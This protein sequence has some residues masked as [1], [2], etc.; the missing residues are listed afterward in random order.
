M[1]PGKW[2]PKIVMVAFFICALLYFTSYAI[3]TLR[4][5]ITTTV[6]HAATVEDSVEGSGLAIR[7]EKPVEGSGD[8]MEV[9]PAE[10][11]TVGKGNP[12]ALI[13]KDKDALKQHQA[14][15]K[16][17][18]E[19]D[20]L[21][22]VISRRSE[23][24]D[25]VQLGKDIITS[26]VSVRSTIAQE[27]LSKLGGEVQSLENMIYQQ[28]YTYQGNESVTKELNQLNEQAKKLQKSDA[29]AVSQVKARWAGTFSTMVDGYENVLTPKVLSGLTPSKLEALKKGRQE[30]KQGTYLGKVV[31]GKIWY[32]AITLDEKDI[33]RMYKGLAVTVR[34]DDAAGD[35]PMTVFNIGQAENGKVVVVFASGNH[36]D[37]TSLLRTQSVS[38]IYNSYNGFRIPKKALRTEGGKY[39]VYRV[40][41]AQLE[42][43]Q[44]K[45]LTETDDYFVVWQGEAKT[46]NGAQTAQSEL[47]KAKQIRDGDT[48]VIRGTNLYDGKVV[49]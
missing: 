40:S 1:K 49:R 10:G 47:E 5:N 12:L 38:V 28:N 24:S 48:I 44:V 41:G 33:Q 26:I 39:Y 3:H 21:Q 7:A 29:A 42:R 16:I 2:I 9:L 14:L 15:E 27:Q 43:T 6:I 19:R 35:Q 36:L 23:S 46:K 31:T 11:E 22:Y 34:F 45:I 25:T 37:E 13:Y 30:V 17:Q 20:T 8:L 4:S 18:A 32:F